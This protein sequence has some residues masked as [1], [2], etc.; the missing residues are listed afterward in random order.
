MFDMHSVRAGKYGDRATLSICVETW[1][2][3]YAVLMM[4]YGVF[5]FVLFLL[6][7]FDFKFFKNS[8]EFFKNKNKQNFLK[9]L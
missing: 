3:R 8:F 1:F 9:F 6:D 4:I 7:P 2:F 5:F